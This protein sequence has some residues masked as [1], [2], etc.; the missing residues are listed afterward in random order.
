MADFLTEVFQ[1][2]FASREK[3]PNGAIVSG[4]T[5]EEALAEKPVT[6]NHLYYG[7][8]EDASAA[9][10]NEAADRALALN[11]LRK[12]FDPNKKAL[13]VTVIDEKF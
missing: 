8:G 9:A 11:Q 13:R 3:V 2:A 4:K 7:A 12:A 1:R 6:G 10:R 5:K